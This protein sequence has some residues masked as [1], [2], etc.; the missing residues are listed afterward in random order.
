MEDSL[1]KS[2]IL[3]ENSHSFFP[4]IYYLTEEQL[5]A[6]MLD[7]KVRTPYEFAHDYLIVKRIVMLD[8]RGDLLS[9]WYDWYFH[10]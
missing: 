4:I 5:V 6:R 1:K 7:D 9:R 3:D 2:F 8:E 10:S